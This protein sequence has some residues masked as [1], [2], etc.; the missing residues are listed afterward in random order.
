MPQIDLNPKQVEMLDE[1][2]EHFVE[3]CE[4]VIE[5]QVAKLKVAEAIGE[6]VGIGEDADLQAEIKVKI[7]DLRA[8]QEEQAT[9]LQDK[10]AVARSIRE[11]LVNGKV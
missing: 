3:K 4:E 6:F 11:L 10:L 5:S 1:M 8:M 2:L 9:S 7:A